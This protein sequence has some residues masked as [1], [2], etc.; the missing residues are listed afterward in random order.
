MKRSSWKRGCCVIQ[1]NFDEDR[2]LELLKEIDHDKS[3]L[4]DFE[5]FCAFLVRVK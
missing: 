5:E 3:G 1:M 2:A 4:I